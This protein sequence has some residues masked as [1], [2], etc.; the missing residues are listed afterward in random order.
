M[1]ASGWSGFNMKTAVSLSMYH[2]F[3]FF[4]G[5]YL[6]ILK[7][8]IIYIHYFLLKKQLYI[9]TVATVTLTR[10]YLS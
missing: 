2:T 7:E 3:S 10:V 4:N 9:F 8:T 1:V 6:F 5:T